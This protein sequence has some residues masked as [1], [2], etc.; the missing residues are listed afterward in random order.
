MMI[1]LMFY[2]DLVSRAANVFCKLFDGIIAARQQDF[3][4]N[5]EYAMRSSSRFPGG[6]GHPRARPFYCQTW[7]WHVF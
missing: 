2:A 4:S 6:I 3:V 1:L 5:Y 7:C